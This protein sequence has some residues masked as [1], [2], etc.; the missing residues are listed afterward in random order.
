MALIILHALFSDFKKKILLRN[1]E[2]KS[3][4]GKNNSEFP[5]T[6]GQYQVI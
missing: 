2:E 5:R 3:K 6:V 4:D 1:I